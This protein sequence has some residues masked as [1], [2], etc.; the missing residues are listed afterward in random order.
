[1]VTF[2]WRLDRFEAFRL[3]FGP[4]GRRGS[5]QRQA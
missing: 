2:Y 1:V 3:R 5:K 4:L